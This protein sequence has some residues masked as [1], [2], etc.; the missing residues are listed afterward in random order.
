MAPKF[1]LPFT[2]PSHIVAIGCALLL[3][4]FFS[5]SGYGAGDSMGVWRA[6]PRM[7]HLLTFSMLLGMQFWVSFVAGEHTIM[8]M[9]FKH[10]LIL[11]VSYVQS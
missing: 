1:D 10:W 2:Q 3:A 9:Q 5:T 4:I 6:V 8:N 11:V 7:C